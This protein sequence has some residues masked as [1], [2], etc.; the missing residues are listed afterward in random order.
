MKARGRRLNRPPPRVAKSAGTGCGPNKV[1]SA[2]SRLAI[3]N[4]VATVHA[5][6][7]RSSGEPIARPS[8]GGGTLS[9]RCVTGAIN[10]SAPTCSG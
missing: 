10:A 2:R 7:R 5:I 9:G 8:K 4:G 6:R 1:V 3:A